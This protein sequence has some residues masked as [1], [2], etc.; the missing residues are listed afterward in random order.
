MPASRRQARPGAGLR[1]AA[2]LAV[3]LAVT[4][5]SASVGIFNKVEPRTIDAVARD[6]YEGDDYIVWVDCII[7]NEGDSGE[8]EVRANLQPVTGGTWGRTQRV[9]M[10]GGEQ[11]VVTFKFAQAYEIRPELDHYFP[12]C[13]SFSP[14]TF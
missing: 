1:L 14:A 7:L 9:H 8:V 3:L 5:C 4:A 10:D 11:A 12:S 6:G 2:G 13:G